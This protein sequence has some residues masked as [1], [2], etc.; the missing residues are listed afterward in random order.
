MNQLNICRS[1]MYI[2][3]LKQNTS[4]ACVVSIADPDAEYNLCSIIDPKIDIK[5]TD[6]MYEAITSHMLSRQ[7]F[8]IRCNPRFPCVLGNMKES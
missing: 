6:V 3:G 1:N 5:D 7:P 8:K 2:P 4:R